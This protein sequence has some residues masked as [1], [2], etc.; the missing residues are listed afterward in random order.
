MPN[1]EFGPI[2]LRSMSYAR[3]EDLFKVGS[4]LLDTLC[5]GWVLYRTVNVGFKD[6]V[7]L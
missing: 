6:C 4:N 1:A 2:R 5:R 7:R 3:Q